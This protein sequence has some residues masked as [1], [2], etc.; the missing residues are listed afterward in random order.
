MNN[1]EK[2]SREI[3]LGFSPCPNDTFMFD[4]LVNGR[5]DTGELKF[6]SILE[7]VETLNRMAQ[8]PEL[9]VTKLSFA[10]YSGVIDQY[11]LLT[12]GSALGKGV[13]PLFISLKDY[14]NSIDQIR[15]VAIPGKNTTAYFLFRMFYPQ[16]YEVKEM[17]FS[18]IEQAILE[19]KV[20]AGVIIHENRFTYEKKGLKKINDLGELWEKKTGQPIP[21]GGIAVKRE[22]DIEVKKKINQLVRESVE[23]AFKNPEASSEYVKLHSQEM[24]EEVQRKHIKLYVNDYSISLGEKGCNAI[25][26]FLEKTGMNKSSL[27]VFVK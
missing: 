1:H 7:D 24:S 5:I 14:S 10:A 15:T 11:M 3:T 4:A 16:N 2:K 19:G 20:D 17:I 12:S 6:K 21:L 23:Y 9:D 25:L 13:G 26:H 27:N 18:E 22:L 8:K